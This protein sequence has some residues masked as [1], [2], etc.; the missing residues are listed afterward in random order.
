MA[1]WR[2]PTAPAGVVRDA[3]WRPVE[4]AGAH[5]AREAS[6]ALSGAVSVAVWQCPTAPAVDVAAEVAVSA[7]PHRQPAAYWRPTRCSIQTTSVR[8]SAGGWMSGSGGVWGIGAGQ[9][10]A[11]TR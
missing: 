8:V 2:C 6:G 7:L 4:A 11:V 3:P 1:V 9:N 5:P 10:V